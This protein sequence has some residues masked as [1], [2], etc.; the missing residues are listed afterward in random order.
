[1]NVLVYAGAG[2]SKSSVRGALATLTLLLTPYYSVRTIDARALIE[3]PWASSTALLVV[4]GGRDV[5]FCAALRGRGTDA[6]RSFVSKGGKYLGLCAGAYFAASRCEFEASSADMAVVGDRD[7]G[8]F[9][10]VVR[11]C[12]FEGFSYDS[13]I[14]ARAVSIQPSTQMPPFRCYWNGGGVFVDAIEKPGVE[15]IARYSESADSIVVGG[16]DACVVKCD[17]DRGVAVLSAVH[18]EIGPRTICT[19]SH[20]DVSENDQID[21]N[22]DALG[23]HENARLSFFRSILDKR[24]CLRVNDSASSLPSL[25]TLQLFAKDQGS[26]E[27]LIAVLSSKISKANLIV[28]ENDTF[29]IL[30]DGESAPQ[31]KPLADDLDKQIKYVSLGFAEPSPL[32][33]VGR[34]LGL[35][36]PHARLGV[37]G[38]YAEV[39]TSS[40]TMLD[41]NFS[42]SRDLPHG[43][44]M[45]CSHQLSGRGRGGNSWISPPGVLSFSLILYHDL[46]DSPGSGG[47]AGLVFFQYLISLAT[48]E[49]LLELSPELELGIKWPND[50]YMR[51]PQSQNTLGTSCFELEGKYYAKVSGSLISTTFWQDK[52]ILTIG[53]G[54]NVN[55]PAPT[56]S[57]NAFVKESVAMENLLAALL[58]RL[59][60][61]VAKFDGGGFAA[62]AER[63]YRHWLHNGQHVTIEKEGNLRGVVVGIHHTHGHLQVRLTGERGQVIGVQADGNSFDM[64]RGLLKT[65]W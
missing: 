15:V 10:G 6:I 27:K 16:G 57:V 55:N 25:S 46:A 21:L 13:E 35:L 48:V 8:F 23:K 29:Q 28:C 14:G 36:S 52:Y 9:P 64:M 33:D 63:Y 40:Q 50:V 32:F 4:P 31:I 43:T 7:L 60:E 38:L 34:F 49:A 51:V 59:E 12:A 37:A 24:L 5:P 44:L 54:V 18:P 62:I 2:T 42:L 58:S 61:L 17:V 41:K 26:R 30:S 3:E 1:M 20:D 65:K 47:A 11:G 45:L 39:V 19:G 22:N 53:C 56:I